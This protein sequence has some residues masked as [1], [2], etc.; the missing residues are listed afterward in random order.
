MSHSIDF[1]ELMMDVISEKYEINRAD[2]L[3]VVMSD[4][5]ITKMMRHPILDTLGYF[6][7]D[8]L[9]KSFEK[10]STA[11]APTPMEDGAENPKAQATTIRIKKPKPAATATATAMTTDS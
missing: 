8:D 9:S 6:T 4:E 1:C 3:E 2:I 10:L 11:T 7:E 5:R